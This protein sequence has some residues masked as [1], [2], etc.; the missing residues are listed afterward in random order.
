MFG[1]FKKRLFRKMIAYVDTIK[2]S[3][4]SK[5]WPN[6]EKQQD[7]EKAKLLSASVVNRLF[8]SAVSPID[9]SLT[10]SQID[11]LAT[12][13]LQNE[14]DKD[15]LYGIVM[16]LRTLMT[17]ETAA[18]NTEGM[19]RILDTMHWLKSIISLPPEKPDP[20]MMKHLAATL[21]SRY[22]KK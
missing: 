18:R 21:Q 6:L 14:D 22:F 3:V 4:Y 8:G 19:N 7:Q 15:L 10:A 13:F 1:F 9:P 5:L 20:N 16:S 12:N 11:D 17:V 2:L